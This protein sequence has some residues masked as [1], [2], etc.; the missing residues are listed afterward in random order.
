MSR[1]DEHRQAV[2]ALSGKTVAYAVLDE[3]RSYEPTGLTLVFTDGTAL[4]VKATDVM[5]DQ[6]SRTPCLEVAATPSE[7]VAPAPD[8][9]S[10]LYARLSG[11]SH[12]QVWHEAD[13][14]GYHLYIADTS[15]GD[16]PVFSVSGPGRRASFQCPAGEWLPVNKDTSAADYAWITP[17]IESADWTDKLADY[18]RKMGYQ[19]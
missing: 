2:S 7:G 4:A 16:G 18:R 15:F 13:V 5:Y 17:L 10:E 9:L 12:R 14:G 8:P 19:R 3:R 1:S 11:P 6:Y